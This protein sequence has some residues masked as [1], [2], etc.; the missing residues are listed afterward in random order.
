M[1][2]PSVSPCLTTQRGRLNWHNSIATQCV[3]SD[4]QPIACACMIASI[5]VRCLTGYVPFERA[6]VRRGVPNGPVPRHIHKNESPNVE[7]RWAS[8]VASNHALCSARSARW[9]CFCQYG[10][11]LR[12]VTRWPGRG[13]RTRR[14][15]GGFGGAGVAFGRKSFWVVPLER[16]WADG[17]TIDISKVVRK[18][19]H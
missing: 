13:S 1:R 9:T 16:N 15:R 19:G 14:P 8:C 6:R 4:G 3:A 12:P 18:T 17:A 2:P 5:N 10:E 11:A 7:C